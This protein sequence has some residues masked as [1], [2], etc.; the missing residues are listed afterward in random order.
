MLIQKGGFDRWSNRYIFRL[1]NY[2][3]QTE[4]PFILS[5]YALGGLLAGV[6]RELGKI[7]S[8]LGFLVGSSIISF[9]INGYMISFINLKELILSIIIF[10]I[11]YKPLNRYISNYIDIIVGR[12]KEKVIFKEKNS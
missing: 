7:G 8:I 6:F 5:I 11:V 1:T 2:I 3:S 9:Y 12:D 4:M 10:Y